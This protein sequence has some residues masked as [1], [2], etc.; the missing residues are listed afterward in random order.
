MILDLFV[1]IPLYHTFFCPSNLG[2]GHNLITILSAVTGKSIEAIVNEYSGKGYGDFKGDVA[3]AV[4][5]CIRPIRAEFDRISVDKKYLT[6][7]YED[8]AMKSTRL[9][10]RT[11]K[12]VYK[13][14]G[15][16]V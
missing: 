4:V 6:S 14:V 12:K 11:L 9:A 16:V 8:G 3:E 7:I 13:K 5:E 10:E 1:S 15:F 2:R